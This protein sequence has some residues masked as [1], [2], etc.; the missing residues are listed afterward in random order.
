MQIK[1]GIVAL[2]SMML[3]DHAEEPCSYDSAQP[4]WKANLVGDSKRLGDNLEKNGEKKPKADREANLSPSDWPSQAHHI[5]PHD[6]INN[7]PVN[8]WLKEGD[9]LWADTQYD[10]DHENNGMWMPYAS[11]LPEWK[12][13]K[14][15]SALM[16][17][18]MRLAGIQIH[19]GRHSRK[20]TYGIGIAPYKARVAHYL[21]KIRYASLSHYVGRHRCKDCDTKKKADKYPPRNNTVQFVHTASSLLEKEIRDGK[22]FVSKIAAEYEITLR[23][24]SPSP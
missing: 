16:F 11:I 17:K 12:K 15:N 21:D 9:R 18:I 14:D 6:Q 4:T 5:I 2:V 22:I 1:E 24:Q 23:S 8:D 19:Q 7:H 20:K 10:V 13:G 3:K